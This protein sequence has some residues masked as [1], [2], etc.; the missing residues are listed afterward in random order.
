M[1]THGS[2]E[3]QELPT[4][5]GDGV[6]DLTRELGAALG[7]DLVAVALTGSVVR[8]DWCQ[9]TSDVN[10]LV[11]VRATSIP[12]LDAM[13]PALA[14]ARE[15]WGCAPLVVSE[16]DLHRSTDVFPIRFLDAQHH[17]RLV[18]GR[19]VLAELRIGPAHVRLRCEQEL[20]NLQLRLQGMYLRRVG[21]PSRVLAALM[22]GTAAFLNSLRALLFLETGQSLARHADVAAAA[23]TRLSLDGALLDRLLE[24]RRAPRPLATTEL[25]MLYERFMGAVAAAARAVDSRGPEGTA[26]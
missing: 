5:V 2:P 17:H 21:Y 16:A 10:V 11:V 19:D 4:A 22:H 15:G 13:A 6:R 9:A 7:H 20:R 14:A 26:P 8:G 18:H 24:L 3:T 23:A 1:E 12:A 25:R